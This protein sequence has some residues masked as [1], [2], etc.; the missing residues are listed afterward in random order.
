MGLFSRK[1]MWKIHYTVTGFSC[2]RKTIYIKAKDQA[3]ACE[4]LEKREF[5]FFV[6]IIDISEVIR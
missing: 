6:S 5:P 1:K 2:Y 3:D 4:E